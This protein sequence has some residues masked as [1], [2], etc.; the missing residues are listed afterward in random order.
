MADSRARSNEALRVSLRVPRNSDDPRH[1][2]FWEWYDRLPTTV[3]GRKAGL[4]ERIM[5]LL[6]EALGVQ[7]PFS[8]PDS[9]AAPARPGKSDTGRQRQ[10]RKGRDTQ[11]K[12][13]GTRKSSGKD[14]EPSGAASTALRQF[15]F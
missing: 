6:G 11:S 13:A 10:P 7:A 2:A 3:G 1:R 8:R 15:Q 4:Q 9:S 12:G 14:K 5:D